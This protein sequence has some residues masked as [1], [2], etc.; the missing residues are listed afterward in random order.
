MKASPATSSK[1]KFPR[2]SIQFK[3]GIIK[4]LIIVMSIITVVNIASGI[5]ITTLN[6]IVSNDIK[7]TNLLADRERN[8]RQISDSMLQTMLYMVSVIQGTGSDSDNSREAF[9]QQHLEDLPV[10]LE[11]LAKEFQA[12][13]AQFT[14]EGDNNKYTGQ[15]A[16][17]QMAYDNL[18]SIHEKFDDNMSEFD[19]RDLLQKLLQTYTVMLQY[20][21][22]K[23]DQRFSR[24]VADTKQELADR[25]D[26]TT[27]VIIVNMI[28]LALLPFLMSFRV[29]ANIRR[30]LSS[31]TQR[32]N[33]Y[34]D[35]DFTFSDSYRR[36]NEF[37][38]IDQML[39]ELGNTLRETIRSTHDVSQEVLRISDVMDGQSKHS[40]K[41]SEAVKNGVDHS[42][43]LLQ[44]QHD[45]TASISSITEQVSASS[46]EIDASSQQV[47]ED[48]QQ[49]RQSAQLGLQRMNAVMEQVNETI[50]Q[51]G[52]LIDS[53]RSTQ[54]RYGQIGNFMMGIQEIN[55]QTN[56]L[57][58]NAS[59]ESARAGEHGRGFAVVAEE[60]RKLSTQ[61][62]EIARNISV[63]LQQTRL[64]M[65]Q[66]R[67]R[68][69][70]FGA[71]IEQT[72][73]AS[74][75]ASQTFEHLE[76]QSGTLSEQMTDISAAIGE[77]SRGMNL[78]VESVDNLVSTSTDVNERMSSMSQL[79]AQQLQASNE[80]SDLSQN[81]KQ[82]SSRLQERTS[83]FK[84]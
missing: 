27:A 58:L 52:E 2:M 20:S 56:L 3:G 71:V 29:A 43:A 68:M 41:M 64:D 79:A 4:Q 76:S 69:T 12:L 19:Q 60:I 26:V 16:V 74:Q 36:Q 18:V 84:I 53:F 39:E 21:S 6:Q 50:D 49:M 57:S 37:G 17:I 78:I 5:T 8:Y 33:A 1:F 67:Q 35:N 30:G 82:A 9:I 59:I 62:D 51:F 80:L 47:N 81:L 25:V 75:H 61:T 48:M 40:E 10:K 31:I 54:E 7:T 24:D 34:K 66:S 32:I 65:E 22:E 11:E 72:K 46:Q 23:L 63:E 38:T 83:I 55:Q 77:I 28:M 42:Q 13:D 15:I 45:E 73:E 70:A 44:S 14:P